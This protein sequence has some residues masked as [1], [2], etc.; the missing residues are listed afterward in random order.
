MRARRPAWSRLSTATVLL[1][2]AGLAGAPGCARHRDQQPAAAPPPA[3]PTLAVI[4]T[5]D[6]RGRYDPV[7]TGPAARGGLARRA[8][9]VDRARLDA[10]A[11][12]QVDAGDL[13]PSAGDGG[14][15]DT[16]AR[17]NLD[18][19]LVMRAT[20]RMGVDA[21]LPGERELALG[22]AG[23][24]A[25]LTEIKIP[26]VAANVTSPT[27]ERL[28]DA[29]RLIEAAGHEVGVFGVVDLSGSLAEAL[30]RWGFALGDPVAAAR[31]AAAS[32][33]ARGAQLVIA[34]VHA[35]RGAARA[36]EIL[37]AAG[38]LGGAGPGADVVVVGHGGGPADAP[39][40]APPP[41]NEAGHGAPLRPDPLGATIGRLDLRG[42]PGGGWLPL[43]N[44]LLQVTG[45]VNEQHGVALIGR[46]ATIPLVDNGRL[47][48]TPA[49]AGAAAQKSEPTEIWTYGST[50]GCALCHQRQAA[51]WQTTD[52]ARA[53]ATLQKNGHD[54]DAACLGCHTTGLLEPGGTR[55]LKT[56]TT[57]FHDVGCESCHGPSAAHV[58]S[59]DKHKGTSR[60]V[61]PLV[62]LGCHTPD[63]NVGP[64]DYAAAR[65]E[66]LGPGHGSAPTGPR[67]PG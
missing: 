26:L 38:L 21:V 57:Y 67:P 59:A 1:A 45:A 25:L 34:L 6:V 30:P 63:Q 58:R 51:Q 28:F 9:L 53:L 33:R 23:L 49:E 55:N 44:Q 52:H 47:A 24:E 43:A 10:D 4:Y 56:A 5:A 60:K 48:N 62:C 61:D 3:R 14:G 46:A 32:L 8:T 12:V 20:R 42:A 64:F 7:G 54:R 39:A 13:L 19:R 17:V 31:A 2:T 22:A 27:G 18:T 36:R 66:I 35:D 16:V 65:K 15:A 50:P 11:V 41:A 40:P 37:T 29:D